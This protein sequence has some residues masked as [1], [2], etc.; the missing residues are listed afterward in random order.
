VATLGLSEAEREAIERLERDVIRPSMEALVILEFC[1]QPSPALAK[2]ATEY[3]AKGVRTVSIDVA[4]EKLIAAQFRLQVVP[5]VYAFFQGQPVADLTAYRSE[6]QLKAALDQLLGQ[7]KLGDPGAAPQADIEPL[8]A[9]GEQ[10]LAEGDAARA[11]SIFRQIRDMAPDDADVAGALARA[12]VAGGETAEAESVL[13]ALPPESA[14]KPA[15]A[16]A[17]AALELAA[18]VPAAD[19][20]AIEA[21]IARN[22]DDHEARFELAGAKAAAGDRDAA[23]DA[24]L[25]II[26]R[27]ADWNEGAARKRFLQLLEAQGLSDP[28]GRAQRRRLSALLFT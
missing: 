13:N 5:T 14:G 9:M 17:R 20:A 15:V 4:K 18:A 8:M 16:R 27:D 7:L 11:A 1:T 25:E 6:T 2:L 22:P 19:T 28:W 10:I 26:A 23:A 12:L 21:R 3:A 24:L